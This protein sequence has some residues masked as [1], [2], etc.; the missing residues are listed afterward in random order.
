MKNDFLTEAVL[1]LVPKAKVSFVGDEIIWLDDRTQPS[2]EA[3]EAKVKELEAQA[4]IDAKSQAIETHIYANYP[5]KKQA[6]D[7]KWTS[8]H[9]TL[10]KAGAVEDL[11]MK[12]VTATTSFFSGASFLDVVAG[13]SEI[14]TQVESFTKLLEIS[15]R[16]QWTKLVIDEGKLSITENR[17]PVYA[18]FPQFD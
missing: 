6:Q 16:T 8:Y 5:Q 7:E 3:I 9:M 13:L 12:I 4:L 18:E 17:E 10:L 1:E 2:K 11:E 14:E 15:I